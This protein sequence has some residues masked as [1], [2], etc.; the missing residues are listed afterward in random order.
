MGGVAAGQRVVTGEEPPDET[1]LIHVM[2]L[3]WIGQGMLL[4]WGTDDPDQRATLN[5]IAVE[6]VDET[7]QELGVEPATDP[8]DESLTD[9]DRTD[10]TG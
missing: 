4:A 1:F 8:R 3:K 7:L 6:A 10:P 5:L 2:L 9:A